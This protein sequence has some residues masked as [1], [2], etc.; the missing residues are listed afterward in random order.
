MLCHFDRILAKPCL[1]FSTCWG[2]KV[3]VKMFR[4]HER[5]MVDATA[6]RWGKKFAIEQMV[7][8]PTLNCFYW[9]TETPSYIQKC[10]K[11]LFIP[12][13]EGSVLG[14]GS[15]VRSRGILEHLGYLFLWSFSAHNVPRSQ[16]NAQHLKRFRESPT[17]HCTGMGI[18]TLGYGI[19]LSLEHCSPACKSILMKSLSCQWGHTQQSIL[20]WNN[21]CLSPLSAWWV[22]V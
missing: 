6:V 5:H 21:Q 2:D 12:W 13:Q 19:V 15:A 9:V 1:L 17:S 3:T 20:D 22:V 11:H 14:T 4:R 16:S 7:S 8:D 18:N 10:L